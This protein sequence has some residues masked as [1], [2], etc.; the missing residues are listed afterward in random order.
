MSH[1]RIKKYFLNLLSQKDY[2]EREL[3]D[4]AMYKG[5]DD[6]EIY[7]EVENLK[8]IKYLDDLR[9][10]KNI[11]ESYRGL[12]GQVWLNYKLA[13]RK[14]SEK[15][16]SNVLQSYD[17]SPSPSFKQK[18]ATKYR[19]SVWS[20]LDVQKKQKIARFIQSQGFNQ[21]FEIIKLWAEKYL[22]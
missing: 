11:V 9:M 2:S 21:P 20:S 8:S 6:N 1:S 14:I 17:L 7:V 5:F 16:I 19:V 13:A 12:K 10:A 15:V 4:K 18:V 22:D 3:I